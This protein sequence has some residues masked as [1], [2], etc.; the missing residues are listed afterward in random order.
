TDGSGLQYM[1]NRYY[2]PQTRRFTELDPEGLAGGVNQ[3]EFAAGYLLSQRDPFGRSADTTGAAILLHTPDPTW[4]DAK[5]AYSQKYSLPTRAIST[6]VHGPKSGPENTCTA[7]CLSDTWNQ[8][9][10]G[11]E[12]VP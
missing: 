3:Y 2:D 5:K 12:E 8:M 9:F 7:N 4:S 10:D 11:R 1:R 6:T